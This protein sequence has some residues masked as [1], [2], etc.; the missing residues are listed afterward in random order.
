MGKRLG[1]AF[2]QVFLYKG[3]KILAVLAGVSLFFMMAITLVTMIFRK[4]PFLPTTWVLGSY[5]FSQVAMAFLVTCG[6]A[7]TWYQ[8]GHIR[9]GVIRDNVSPRK[10]AIIDV[11]AALCALVASVLVVWGVWQLMG[12]YLLYGRAT[13]LRGVPLW[14]FQV[15]F[16]IVVAHFCLVLLRSIMGLV[17]KARGSRWAEEPYLQKQ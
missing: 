9:I 11:V 15:I 17:A 6:I 14:P 12:L 10:R 2:S 5:E 1:R 13:E 4:A 7:W 8:A 3:S 16:C